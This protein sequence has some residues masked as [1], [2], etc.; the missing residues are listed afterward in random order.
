MKIFLKTS[1]IEYKLSIA[2]M[3]HVIRVQCTIGSFKPAPQLSTTTMSNSR[4][5]IFKKYKK[6][7]EVWATPEQGDLLRG[8]SLHAGVKTI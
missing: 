2:R 6:G 7:K 1:R 3:T 4:Q 5:I 8:L